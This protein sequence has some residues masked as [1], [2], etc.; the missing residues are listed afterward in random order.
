MP[1]VRGK[2]LL[3][4]GDSLSA[5]P[6]APGQVMASRLGAAAVRVDARVGRSANNFYAREDHEALIAA[7]LAWR[8]DVVIVWLGT[9]DIG[10]SMSVDGA[11][12]AQIQ[13][14][15]GAGGAEVWALGPPAFPKTGEGSRLEAGAPAVVAMM[16]SVF[17]GRFIDIRGAS[18][19]MAPAGQNG[20]AADGIHFTAAGG[21]ALGARLAQIVH[22]IPEI[23]PPGALVAVGLALVAVAYA[24]WR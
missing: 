23:S 21:E 6:A 16:A 2:R 17:R 14:E 8:P 10:L 22:M 19:P 20:R 7:D 3:L 13:R 11:R 5:S 24:L 12:M 1:D 4:F 18:A 15:L 9:N